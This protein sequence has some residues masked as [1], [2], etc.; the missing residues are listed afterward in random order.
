MCVWKIE[1]H[2]LEWQ[3][4]QLADELTD[5][6]MNLLT[7]WRSD[8]LSDKL[9]DWVMNSLTRSYIEQGMYDPTLALAKNDTNSDHQ[10]CFSIAATALMPI[11]L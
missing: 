6:L 3:A 4:D 5:W 10:R 2:G 7:D 8:W 11:L 1:M 9:T